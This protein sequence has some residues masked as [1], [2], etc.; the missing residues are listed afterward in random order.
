MGTFG[1]VMAGVMGLIAAIYGVGLAVP[2]LRDKWLGKLSPSRISDPALRRA[3]WQFAFAYMGNFLGYALYFASFALRERVAPEWRDWVSAAGTLCT[4]VAVACVFIAVRLQRRLNREVLG[5]EPP[6]VFGTVR[7]QLLVAVVIVGALLGPL[8]GILIARSFGLGGGTAFVFAIVLGLMAFVPLTIYV[9][10]AGRRERAAQ[11]P[12]GLEVHPAET[13]PP[14]NTRR[15][16]VLVLI[17]LAVALA[18]AVIVFVL[19]S[20]GY[21]REGP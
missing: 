5:V 12:H 6:R 8:L 2:G 11:K 16:T 21:C 1:L 19:L 7:S 17:G 13:P 18:T 3:A 9:V 4:F 14:P 10:R 20:R 15:A